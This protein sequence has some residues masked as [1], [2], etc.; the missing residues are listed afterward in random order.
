MDELNLPELAEIEQAAGLVY[1]SM[2][3][4]PRIT[5]SLLHERA[6]CNVWVKHE[7]HNPTGAIKVR[8]GLVAIKRLIDQ[9]K[10]VKAVVAA[11]QHSNHGQSLAF[12]AVQQGLKC[13]VVVPVGN[14]PDKM[15][16]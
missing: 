8:G 12:A 4:S 15:L 2:A 3:P 6:G 13:Y 1:R 14:G 5:W 16:R 9:G 7:N 11:T 10:P